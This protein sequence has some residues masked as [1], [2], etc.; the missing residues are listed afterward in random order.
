MDVVEQQ[1]IEIEAKFSVAAPEILAR[2]AKQ[3]TGL[4]GYRFGAVSRREVVDVYL[5]T[6]DHRLLRTGYQLRIR[7]VDG[8]WRVT[9][10][11]RNGGG[12][13]GIHRR[14]EIEAVLAENS[15]PAQVG[16]LPEA[17]VEALAGIVPESD[18]LDVLCVLEQ[19]RQVRAVTST[20]RGHR[21]SVAPLAMLS[22]DEIRIR[23]QREGALL[24]CAYE[25]ELELLPGVDVAELR[26]LADRFVGAY[27]LTPSW[28]SKLERALVIL[29]RHPA[30][31][32]ESWQGVR[33]EMHMGEACRILW[34]EQL[35]QLLLNE[36]GVRHSED[37]AYVHDARVAIRRA[38]AAAHI[39]EGYFKPK[40]I[41]PH[42]Q[43]LR[44]TARLLGAVRDLDV[45]IAKLERY[46]QKTRRR[47]KADR[48]ETLSVWR[49]Q[50]AVAFA[51]LVEWLDSAK[52]A[53]F[54]VDFLA[55]CR[56]PGA[57]IVDMQPQP[58]ETVT[59]F[60][61]RHVA[62]TMLVTS[63]ERV[64]AYEVWFERPG[65]V[66]VE[67]LHRLRIECK[68][69]RYNLEFMAGL[70]G[71][72]SAGVIDLLHK[73]QDDLG[74]LNDAVVSQ[75]LLSA[76]TVREEKAV[77]RYEQEQAKIIDKLSNQVRGDFVNFVAG[78]NRLCLWS[79]IARIS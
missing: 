64:C 17:I 4:P 8:E 45:A 76:E 60:Q 46:Q 27:D 48:Q 12:D 47:T 34:H 7:V 65:A 1:T 11:T 43:P 20:T 35:T 62:P 59:P 32:P 38:R 41:R 77:A 79:A 52:Y 33:A 25:I 66:P 75:Q 37:P 72:E 24:A 13:I 56:T 29:S 61:V 39:Y 19:T 23:R 67:T 2:L 14:V 10:K 54:V 69:L 15:L 18:L 28:E 70:L 63:F 40:A 6:P 51:A 30:E 73:L 50:R 57:G 22:L 58:G 55:F 44:K 68:Y 5:D 9:F 42:M 26:V 74:D 36:A 21:R 31:S 16:N 3:R 71:P 49:S 53:H 78:A